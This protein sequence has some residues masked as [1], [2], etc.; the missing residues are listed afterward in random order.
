M[1]SWSHIRRIASKEQTLFFASPVAYLFIAAFAALSLF[2]VFWGESFFA[3]NIADTRPLF[4]WMPVLLVFLASALTMRLWSEERRT[5]TLEH[6]LTTPVPIHAFVMGKFLACLSLLGCALLVTVPFTVTVAFLGDLDWGPVLAGY[7]ATFLLGASYIA[8]GLFVSSQSSN[9]IVA[10]LGSVALGG[11][12]YLVGSPQI[13]DLFSEHTAE[14]LRS[15]GTGSRF[16]S[17]TRGVLDVRDLA[18]YAGLILTFL[19]LNALALEAERWTGA[20]RSQRKRDWQAVAILLILNALGLNLWLGQLRGL[21]VDVTEGGLYSLSETTERQLDSLT[22]P[23]VV[24]GYFSQ[25]T[26]P[27]L[28]PLVPQ[29]KDLLREYEAV[30]PDKVKVEIIDPQENPELE[31]EAK[32][33]FGIEPVPF[34]VAD[35]YQ[36]SIVSSYFNIVLKYGDSFETLGFQD[37]IEVKGHAMDNIDVQLRNP[38]YDLTRAVK[39]VVDS[40]QKEG[41]L[42]GTLNEPVTLQ[43]ILSSEEKLPE[44]LREFRKVVLD[45]SEELKKDSDGKLVVEIHDPDTEDQAKSVVKKYGLKP[46]A[47]SLLDSN[48]FYFYI[49]LAQGE[50]AVQLPLD[51]R[52]KGSFE[53]NFNSALKRFGSGFA[54]TVALASKGAVSFNQLKSF[55]GDEL[56]IETEDLSDGGVSAAAETLVLVTGE[57]LEAKE[58]FAVDQFLMRGGTVIAATSGF[59]VD[60]SASELSLQK[61]ETGLEKWLSHHGIDIDKTLV[62]DSQCA[63]LPIP[64][65]RYVGG[66]QM[67]EIRLLNYPYFVDVRGDGFAPDHPATADLGQLTVSWASP[68]NH[69]AP[70][71]S[72]LKYTELL[73]SSDASWLNPSTLVMPQVDENGRAVIAP[74]GEQKSHTLS[75]LAEGS[76]KSYFET[77][78]G[79]K[80]ASELEGLNA[81]TL[82]GSPSSAKLIVISSPT[83]F[84]DEMIRLFSGMGAGDALSNLTFVANAID[85]AS[86]DESLLSIRSRS[87]FKRTLH[88]LDRRQQMMWEYLNYF[89]AL[90]MLAVIAGVQRYR[91]EKKKDLYRSLLGS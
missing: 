22:E 18:Y 65:T 30:A 77:E 35:R 3:R 79:K 62:E 23:L 25:K 33:E 47:A 39:K 36:A 88:P 53:R 68:I 44:S 91:T 12:F 81:T 34:Q 9:Q 43:L 5:G 56:N 16:E 46:M 69:K 84:S 60:Q 45:A 85:W 55:L 26:H 1:S 13:T 70:E 15:L 52:S 73:K 17:I 57:K 80:L 4:E 20:R 8:I 40:Y 86:Q 63:A 27:L 14:L 90:L 58:L 61:T 67:Q 87:H 32:Q 51:D 49:L 6:V 10:L 24:R 37:L 66:Y 64:V 21:R 7:L 75:V 29:L 82:A 89:L 72:E 74:S 50:K 71:G 78:D 38:E 2:I 83:M 28:A 76:F 11:L 19:S 54:K 41:D 42:F 48:R 59:K 31:Q